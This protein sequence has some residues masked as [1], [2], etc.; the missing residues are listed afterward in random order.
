MCIYAI[1]WKSY[2]YY[3]PYVFNTHSL[4]CK[5]MQLPS[6]QFF[7]TFPLTRGSLLLSD[8]PEIDSGLSG[9]VESTST[10]A[11][12]FTFMSDDVCRLMS[13]ATELE[14]G[15]WERHREWVRDKVS[16]YLQKII[17]SKTTVHKK[18]EVVIYHTNQ[19]TRTRNTILSTVKHTGTS[20]CYS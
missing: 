17:F 18:K 10:G 2:K 13:K 7:P 16:N 20:C 9:G 12:S 19:T 5:L 4:L 14:A 15:S 1:L 8:F 11:S 6:S 3:Q